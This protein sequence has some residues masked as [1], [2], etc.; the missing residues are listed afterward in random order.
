MSVV[1]IDEAGRG[2]WAG[3]L[4]VAGVLLRFSVNGLNDSKALSAARR[5]QLAAEISQSAK[6]H[7]VALSNRYIDSKG[8]TAAMRAAVR[9][10]INVLPATSYLVD[11]RQTFSGD[12][13]VRAIIDGDA[14]LP[15][16][17]A[18]SIMAKTH[19]DNLMLKYHRLYPIYGFDRHKGYGTALHRRQLNRY[20]VSPI[21][22]LSFKPV[23]AEY[24]RECS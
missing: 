22:R 23:K 18:A 10:I 14:K 1:G 21:H 11:G 15:S 8:L 9:K 4:V 5:R 12:L 6:V 13:R 7:T 2:A 17:M 20:G 24:A 19:R 3:P 16:I